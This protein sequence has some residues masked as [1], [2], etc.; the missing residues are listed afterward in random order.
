[1]SSPAGEEEGREE[2][3]G[4]EEDPQRRE[5]GR[6][7]RCLFALGSQLVQ[8]EGA[9][10]HCTLLHDT[11]LLLYSCLCIVYQSLSSTFVYRSLPPT[12]EIPLVYYVYML[13]VTVPHTGGV[14]WSSV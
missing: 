9:L 13:C 5:T 7:G 12:I 6:G 3:E 11:T 1:M 10:V 8:D 2:Q 4:K 14:L